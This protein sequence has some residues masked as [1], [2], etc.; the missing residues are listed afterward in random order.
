MELTF[1]WVR[2]IE[3]GTRMID[4]EFEV[5]TIKVKS[6]YTDNN[7][8][9]DEITMYNNKDSRM[10]PALTQIDGQNFPSLDVQ[11][12]KDIFEDNRRLIAAMH[13]IVA[14]ASDTS[15]AI[16]IAQKALEGVK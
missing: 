11:S 7:I 13:E 8:R 16:I 14:N 1:H 15:G 6:G 9:E 5:L 12:I 2:G 4:N 10:V 3:I